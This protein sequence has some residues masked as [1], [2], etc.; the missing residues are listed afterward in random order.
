MDILEAYQ[1]ARELPPSSALASMSWSTAM[2][3]LISVA[4]D[5]ANSEIQFRLLPSMIVALAESSGALEACEDA[6]DLEAA[7]IAGIDLV[8]P[9]G[10]KL[11]AIMQRAFEIESAWRAIELVGHTFHWN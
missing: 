7:T 2:G 6:S 5:G 8:R 9:L 4:P 10:E 1:L 3:T 11:P